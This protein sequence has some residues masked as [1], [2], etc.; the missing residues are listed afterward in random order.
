MRYARIPNLATAGKQTGADPQKDVDVRANELV[1]EA[2]KGGPVAA[3]AS[4]ELEWAL[5][6]NPGAPLAIAVIALI[7]WRVRSML[8]KSLRSEP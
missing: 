7:S 5:P 6:L 3:F 8:R 1:V 2:L 4:E